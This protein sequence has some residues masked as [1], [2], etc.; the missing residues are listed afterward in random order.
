[1]KPVL[2]FVYNADSGLFNT[3]SDIGHKLF[4]PATYQ[5]RLCDITHSYFSMRGEWKEYI[6]QLGLECEFLH[7]D[8]FQ[9]QYAPGDNG[10][11]AAYI[12][13]TDGL[14]RCLG[15]QDIDACT[16]MDELKSLIM[17]RCLP[18]E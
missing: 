2:V 15:P 4:S 13:E 11:P 6:E 3:L 14:R 9:A 1:M 10:F 7:R 17:N 12:K 8:E 16:T 5:C 18:A